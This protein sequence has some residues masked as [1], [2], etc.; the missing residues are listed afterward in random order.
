MYWHH[1]FLYQSVNKLNQSE[2]LKP[3]FTDL[4]AKVSSKDAASSSMNSEIQQLRSRFEGRISLC[5]TDMSRPVLCSVMTNMFI[6]LSR[7]NQSE[8]KLVF[9]FQILRSCSELLQSHVAK[10]RAQTYFLHST[11]LMLSGFPHMSNFYACWSPISYI[12][13]TIPLKIQNYIPLSHLP[14]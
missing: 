6:I 7:W 10:H 8:M 9:F 5:F 11:F 3:M 2:P 13:H 4:T 14:K 12:N 1:N